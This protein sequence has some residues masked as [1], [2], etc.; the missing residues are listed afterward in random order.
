MKLSSIL[1]TFNSRLVNCSSEIKNA[2]ETFMRCCFSAFRTL[3]H[4]LKWFRS[5]PIGTLDCKIGSLDYGQSISVCE[6]IYLWSGLLWPKC[7]QCSQCA[8][9]QL[10]LK[11]EARDASLI[12][13]RHKLSQVYL[14]VK[15]RS[16]HTYMF[17]FYHY[18]MSSLRNKS[19]STLFMIN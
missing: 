1:L 17:S 19:C 11:F 18:A 2:L 6:C 14:N 8:R 7:R 16:K 15:P 10:L 3:D 9:H 4:D 13:S 12:F 5:C